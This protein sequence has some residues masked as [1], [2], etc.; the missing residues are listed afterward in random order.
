[1]GEDRLVKSS[2]FLTTTLMKREKDSEGNEVLKV[3]DSRTDKARGKEFT[4]SMYDDR[5]NG[6]E[7]T[8]RIVN[9]KPEQFQ[10]NVIYILADGTRMWVWV[11]EKDMIDSGEAQAINDA[12]AGEAE[13][14]Q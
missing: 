10:I 2:F 7:H 6:I 5:M 11:E 13:A 4:R 1:M 14:A 3:V 9:S 8:I 12:A